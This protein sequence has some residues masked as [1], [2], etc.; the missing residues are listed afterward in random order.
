[1]FKNF[2]SKYFNNKKP[3]Q[4]VF[5]TKIFMYFCLD[6]TVRCS[7]ERGEEQEARNEYNFPCEQFISGTIMS[8]DFKKQR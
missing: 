3:N 6:F 4:S 1:M 8:L 7:R 5:F 2:G